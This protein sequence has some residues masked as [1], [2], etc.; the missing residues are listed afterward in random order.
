MK[1][2][3]MALN[4]AAK[5]LTATSWIDGASVFHA[6]FACPA[7]TVQ[8]PATSDAAPTVNHAGE[9]IPL[10]RVDSKLDLIAGTYARDGVD[11]IACFDLPKG[12]SSLAA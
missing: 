3:D 10:R 5:E 1:N 9:A 4:V 11:I 2:H 8:A 6:P 12:A 7:F